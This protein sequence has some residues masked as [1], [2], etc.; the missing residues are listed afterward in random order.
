MMKLAALFI[1]YKKLLDAHHIG[2]YR[3]KH[4]SGYGIRRKLIESLNNADLFFRR[5]TRFFQ[6]L[7]Q[8]NAN[9]VNVDIY[10]Y[11]RREHLVELGE[12]FYEVDTIMRNFKSIRFNSSHMQ[13]NDRLFDKSFVAKI[14][15]VPIDIV[16]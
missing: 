3:R 5:Q 7:F 13:T 2:Q 14:C 12:I 11:C 10:L 4:L 6:L 8:I 16:S 9:T 15:Y 1:S